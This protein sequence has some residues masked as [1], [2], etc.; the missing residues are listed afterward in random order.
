[1][2]HDVFVSYATEDERFV[3]LYLAPALFAEGLSVWWD[4]TLKPGEYWESVIGRALRD[5]SI[6]VVLWSRH[7]ASAA[8][9]E[10]EAKAAHFRGT[11][12]GAQLDACEPPEPFRRSGAVSLHHWRGNRRAPAFR[13]LVQSMNMLR[14]RSTITYMR[15]A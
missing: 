7:A 14:Q 15:H 5:A 2:S 3:R 6:C 9:V 10:E 12:V 1:M 13:T 8:L 11:Y 4:H